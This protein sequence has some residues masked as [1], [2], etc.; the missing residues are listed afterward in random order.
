MLFFFF[1]VA[2]GE[3]AGFKHRQMITVSHE[4]W[5]KAPV[6]FKNDIDEV[7]SRQMNLIDSRKHH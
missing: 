4:L 2:L 1:L 6:V 7:G 3:T 5:L